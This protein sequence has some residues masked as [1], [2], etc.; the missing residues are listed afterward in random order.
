MKQTHI[1]MYQCIDMNRTKAND[2]TYT[3]ISTV[4]I[5]IFCFNQYYVIKISV[6]INKLCIE[7]NIHSEM[8]S[9]ICS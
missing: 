1:Q 6:P 7:L 3:I 8:I 2:H 4:C 5:F 9:E